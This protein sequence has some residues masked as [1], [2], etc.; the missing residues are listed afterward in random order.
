MESAPPGWTRY[1]VQSKL[2][3]GRDF[4][5]QDEDEQQVFFVDGKAGIPAKADIQDAAGNV[6]A[7]VRGSLVPIP[8]RVSIADA[9]GDP[10]AE[11]K[12]KAFTPIKARMT[13][14][15]ADGTTWQVAG[16]ILEKDYT[17]TAE[18]S[19]VLAIS[20]KWLKVRDTYTLDLAEGTSM[21]IALALLWTVDRWAERT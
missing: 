3:L 19:P 14:T 13:L 11:L 17:V 4:I 10:M 1:V 7:S 21:P 9:A 12:A 2:G 18:G 5:V 6:V 8:K 15:M 20:Q 16:E